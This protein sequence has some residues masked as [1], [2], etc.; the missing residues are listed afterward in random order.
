MIYKYFKVSDIDESVS[1]LNE[2]LK[3]ELKNDSV[4]SF[5]TRWDD[6]IVAIK[7]HPDDQNLGNV[8]YRQLPSS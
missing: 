2:I 4:Q 5:S 1:D 8:D 3:V 6:T 7:K